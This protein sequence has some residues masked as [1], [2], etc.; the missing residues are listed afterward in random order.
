MDT[1]SVLDIAKKYA[2]IVA[3]S[4]AV[5]KIL[6]FGSHAKGKAKDHS[7]IDIAVIV[8]TIEGEQLTYG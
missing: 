2:E 5:Q 4:F 1:G 7:N 8:K 3:R 6:L